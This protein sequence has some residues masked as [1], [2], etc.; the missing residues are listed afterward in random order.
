MLRLAAEIYPKFWNYPTKAEN[1]ESVQNKKL[2]KH[3][4]CILPTQ[5]L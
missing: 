1:F 5:S 3:I 2:E 4:N